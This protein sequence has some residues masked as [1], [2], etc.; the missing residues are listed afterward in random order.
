MSDRPRWDWRYIAFCAL[1][2]CAVL[3]WLWIMAFVVIKAVA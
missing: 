2:A 3:A 1:S